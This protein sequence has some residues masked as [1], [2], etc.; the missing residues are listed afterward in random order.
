MLGRA[1]T[2]KPMV[3]IAGD[4]SHTRIWGNVIWCP[5]EKPPESQMITLSKLERAV[6][7]HL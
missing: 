4:H 3:R 5:M 1:I 7:V 6:N 2:G